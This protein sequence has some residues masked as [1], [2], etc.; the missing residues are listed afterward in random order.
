MHYPSFVY[1]AVRAKTDCI[2]IICPFDTKI[3]HNTESYPHIFPESYSRAAFPASY[4]HTFS[5]R[6]KIQYPPDDIPFQYA[7]E[8]VTVRVQL[9]V[10]AF[11]T[12]PDL[13]PPPDMIRFEIHN[14]QSVRR[15]IT[16][17]HNAL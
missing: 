14:H 17:V 9:C 11:G 15:F 1:Y 2:M 12:F 4:F 8:R 10:I 5:R 13:F 6:E 16:A 3:N 7:F